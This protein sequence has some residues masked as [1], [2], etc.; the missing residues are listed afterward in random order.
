MT[1]ILINIKY[2]D[3]E[4]ILIDE[5]YGERFIIEW[6]NHNN[7]TLVQRPIMH[8]FPS[9]YIKKE[10]NIFFDTMTDLIEDNFSYINKKEQIISDYKY[11]GYTGIGILSESHISIHT[12]PEQRILH[13]D[14][15]SCKQLDSNHNNVFINKYLKK[16]NTKVFDV[17]YIN[18]QL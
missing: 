12:Y 17:K 8:I 14:F 16:S 1:H 4:Q 11:Y 13:I 2:T 10:N 7:H 6:T 9:T 5:K 3:L 18:R 15:F